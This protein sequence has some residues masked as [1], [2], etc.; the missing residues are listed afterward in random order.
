MILTYL[1]TG[2]TSLLAAGVVVQQWKSRVLTRQNWDEVIARLQ[3]TATA[4]ITSIAL[5]YLNPGQLAFKTN[6]ATWLTSLGGIRGIKHMRIN[7]DLL[8][9]LAAQ[10]ERWNPEATRSLVMQMRHD[11]AELRRTS[12]WLSLHFLDARG[13][14]GRA[15]VERAAAAYYRMIYRLLEAVRDLSPNDFVSLNNAVWNASAG[16]GSQ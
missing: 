8:I 3:P 13:E 7:G 12:F 11:G 10:A 16:L 5:E 15:C 4:E 1:L 9:A 2:G 14:R 6:A